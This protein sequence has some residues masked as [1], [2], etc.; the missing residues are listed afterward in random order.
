MVGDEPGKGKATKA[1]ENSIPMIG[2][3]TLMKV[4]DG[5]ISINEAADE[6]IAFGS[7]TKFSRGDDSFKT[8]FKL[9]ENFRDGKG[10]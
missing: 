2:K 3:M 7:I 8:G 4:I 6:S 9:K 5:K 10:H 1:D